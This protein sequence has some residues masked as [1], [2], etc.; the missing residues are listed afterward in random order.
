MALHETLTSLP[1]EIKKFKPSQM[2]MKLAVKLGLD[3]LIPLG[4]S[5]RDEG[6]S[7]GVRTMEEYDEK[8]DRGL[9]YV[10]TKNDR[11]VAS[12][13]VTTWTPEDEYGEKFW[14]D[15]KQ[16]DRSLFKRLSKLSTLGIH[17]S[18]ITTHPEFRQKGLVT[19]LYKTLIFENEPAFITG[20]TKTPEAVIARANA[21]RKLGPGYRTFYG[22]SEV[23]PDKPQD[24]T[25]MH[26]SLLNAD[27]Y[28]IGNVEEFAP[29]SSVFFLA[30][31]LPTNIPDTSNLPTHIQKAFED[32]IEAQKN[33]N[34]KG[35]TKIAVK[36]LMSVRASIRLRPQEVDDDETSEPQEPTEP[37][38]ITKQR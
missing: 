29:G 17:I 26:Q 13:V 24:F 30:A 19:N 21:L 18:G 3:E 10:A 2:D 34:E 38:T 12:L 6:A 31:G 28:A 25:N 32:V 7:A 33:T 15:L 4:Y 8:D 22:N 20:M 9:I 11:A 1:P 37:I 35:G 5:H 27:L 36:T 14:A 16:K 23:T